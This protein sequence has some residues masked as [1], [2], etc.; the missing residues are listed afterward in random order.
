MKKALLAL[1]IGGFGIGMTEFVI[2]GILPEV[3]EAL[4]ITIPQAGHFI[5][6]YALGVVVGAPLLTAFGNKWPPHKVLMALMIWFT[7]FNTLSA[8]SNSYT[9]LLITR[10]LSGLPHGA[11]FGIGAVVAGKLAKPG[12]DAQAIAMMF[13]GLTV[14]NVIGVPL[15]T[16]LGQNFEW[17][18]A[19]LAVGVVG[20]L[21]ILSVK[22]W[23]PELPKTKSNGFKKDIKVLKK[24][25]LWMVILLT[26]IGTGGFFAW[27]SYIA[28]LITDVAGHEENIVS[29]AM[30]LA[31]LGMVAGNF[32]GAKLAEM[33]R[34]IYAVIIALVCMVIALISNTFLAYDQIGVL[35]M[36]FILPLIAFCIATPIQMAVINSAKGSEMLG[37]SLNQSAFNMGNASGAY[38]AGLPIAYG[39]GIVSA[40]YVG[41]AMAGIGIFIGLGVIMIRRHQAAQLELSNS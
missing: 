38:L 24:P 5:S 29:Y 16:W 41:A 1:A 4:S 14:A 32:I 31:G 9:L 21:A 3:A 12:K 17:G 15:G 6:A 18:V 13:T 23:M 27:Y 20:I 8:F 35:I 34:P 7:I 11:F 36:T 22:F 40:Q 10:F 2:M 19:F 28:P 39:Y 26:T 25:E 30:I 37:S 33:F